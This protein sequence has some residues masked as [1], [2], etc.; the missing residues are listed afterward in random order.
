MAKLR[1][2]IESLDDVDEAVQG[3]YTEKDGK[4]HLDVEGLRTEDDVANLQKVTAKERDARLQSEKELK[5]LQKKFNAIDFDKM[6]KLEAKFRELEEAGLKEKGDIDGLVN[7]R[8]EPFMKKHAQEIERQQ[9]KQKELSDQLADRDRQIHKYTV[10]SAIRDAAAPTIRDGAVEFLLD[11]A[12]KSWRVGED[13]TPV[14]IGENGEPVYSV[15]DP[16]KPIAPDEW[17]EGFRENH[18]FLFKE[19]TGGGAKGSQ[20]TSKA[21]DFVMTAEQVDGNHSAYAAMAAEAAKVGKTVQI[22]G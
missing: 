4:F 20:I 16:T 19:S 6:Q 15:A 14:L 7:S 2:V 13:G 11:K 12:D 17:I 10:H 5:A 21:G 1:A 8:L 9:A 22:V 3:L 18:G